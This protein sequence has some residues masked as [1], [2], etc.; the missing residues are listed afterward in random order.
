MKLH[1]FDHAMQL[2][3]ADA[4]LAGTWL[5]ATSP[6]YGNMVGPFGGVTA[7]MLL[8]AV[9]LHPARL[10]EPV[11][12]TVNFAAALSDGAFS[13]VAE[14]VR[15]NRSTQHW[16]LRLMQ[17][18]DSGGDAVAAT[19]S[20]VTALRRATRSDDD[21]PM[22]G[23]AFDAALPRLG[24][25]NSAW[26][27]RYDMRALRGSIPQVWDGSQ[28]D[29]LTQLWIRD[30]PPRPLDFLSLA[31]MSDAFFPRIWLRRATRVP[32]GTVSISS[33]FH[34]SSAELARVGSGHLLGQARAQ[35]FHNG[36]FD[37]SAQLW[38]PAGALLATS[39]Q[40]VYY[41]E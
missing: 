3:P 39:N 17:A 23:V 22:P 40:V 27:E 15:T 16:S 8:Q 24:I 37:Q 6:A 5:G 2:A 28:S 4:N 14:P 20:V 38:S 21:L 30:E 13:I 41:K 11:A 9:L 18:S 1:P 7:A 31:A 32:A 25:T 19:A 33:Y 36:F 12:L 34:A 29:S 10:G 26:T 35:R